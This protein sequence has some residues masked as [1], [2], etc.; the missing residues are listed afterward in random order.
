MDKN[1][2]NKRLEQRS[3]WNLPAPTVCMV[4][5]VILIGVA[6]IIMFLWK[7]VPKIQS[8][9]AKLKMKKWNARGGN[10]GCA[11]P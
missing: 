9:G 4:V 2:E 5:A 3:L 11:M 7:M 1:E 10:C 8:G 6:L